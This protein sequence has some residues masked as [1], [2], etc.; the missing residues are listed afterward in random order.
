[1]NIG[2]DSKIITPKIGTQM[3]GYTPR[4][5]EGIHDNLSESTMYINN[6]YELIIIS[7]DIVAIPQYRADRIKRRIFEQYHIPFNQIIIST[8]HTHSG[9]TVTDLLLDEP[10]IDE[11]FWGQITDKIVSSAS[12]SINNTVNCSATLD[13]HKVL[14]GAYKNRNGENLPYNDNIYELK[15]R[16][17]NNLE[18]SVILIATHPTIMN[19]NN[20]MISADLIGQIRNNYQSD[21]GIYQMVLLSDCGDTSTRYTRQE[22]TFN[23]VSRIGNIVS[24]SLNTSI[25]KTDLDFSSMSVSEVLFKCDYDAVNNESSNSMWKKINDEY[26]KSHDDGINGLL[27]TYKHI[28]YYGH[29]KFTAKAIILDFPNFRIVTYPGELVNTLG[30]RIRT[31]DEKPTLLITLANDYRGYSVD[32]KEFGRYFE[33]YNSVFLKGMADEFVDRICKIGT[34]K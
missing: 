2:H 1:M 22:S 3:E 9:P 23:E 20:K 32:N 18:T 33:S 12:Y 4:F 17:N 30:K 6:G 16:H 19:V 7:I 26:K 34:K 15:F 11:S 14:P 24:D 29:T 25:K 5:S 27:N 13:C 10:E 31:M 28:R 8:I 21:N